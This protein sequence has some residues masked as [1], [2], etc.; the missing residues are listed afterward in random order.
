[1]E[2]LVG[3]LKSRVSPIVHKINSWSWLPTLPQYYQYLCTRIYYTIEICLAWNY[4]IFQA[5]LDLYFRIFVC[6][7]RARSRAGSFSHLGGR[8][9]CDESGQGPGW[10]SIPGCLSAS[11]QW[12]P[13]CRHDLQW[14]H[15]PRY[16]RPFYFLFK[17]KLLSWRISFNFSKLHRIRISHLD[18]REGIPAYSIYST[19]SRC[20]SVLI[21]SSI[22]II[23]IFIALL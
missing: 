5:F 21:S 23:V 22:F 8:R 3:R 2:W 16:A 15:C 11:W 12:T 7:W 17:N 13:F 14:T 19:N 20:I 1:M 18:I 6:S 10:P 4:F 9:S